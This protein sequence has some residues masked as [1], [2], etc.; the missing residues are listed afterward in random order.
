MYKGET[1]YTCHVRLKISS[2]GS[3]TKYESFL[4]P[5]CDCLRELSNRCL[6]VGGSNVRLRFATL[7]IQQR[8]LLD[9]ST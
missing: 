9:I 4:E 6:G 1:V 5:I 2:G 8:F 7:I 3:A